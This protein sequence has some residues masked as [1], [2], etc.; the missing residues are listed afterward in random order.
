MEYLLQRLCW[1]S[2]GYQYPAG[3]TR[4]IDKG[5]S[6]EHGFGYE[7]WN[8]NTNDIIDNKCYGY[9]YQTPKHSEEKIYNIYFFSKDNEGRDL[10]IGLYKEAKFLDVKQRFDLR[11]KFKKSEMYERRRLELLNL[12]ISKK[13]ADNYILGDTEEE[14]FLFPLNICVDPK[15]IF[16][17]EHPILMK[18]LFQERL[19]YHYTTAENIT[20]ER[21]KINVL[22][23][24]FQNSKRED[25][26]IIKN[27]DLTEN[28][29]FRSINN[30]I[31][32]IQ[33]LHNKLSNEFKKYLLS[34]QFYEVEQENCSLDMIAK[35]NSSTYMFELKIVNTPFVRHS[36]REALGQL[37]EYNYYPHRS[38]FDYLNIVLNR[39]PS[40][41]EIDWCKKL[42]QEVIKF[43][44][45][46]H[47]NNIF[48]C[49]NLSQNPNFG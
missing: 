8:F 27:Y 28:S 19:N 42:N 38:K 37:L 35:K 33:P 34:K 16:L 13:L 44:L 40:D 15:N 43:E 23:N 47:S 45:F 22:N 4:G 26:I 7:E 14:K 10:L 49:A 21:K 48:E 20:N 5:F 1:N 41:L 11:E 30:D 6:G 32:L 25:L 24:C 31:K 29:Y 18:R 2:N 36:I 46:W 12:D 39:K 3:K 17:L 9:M